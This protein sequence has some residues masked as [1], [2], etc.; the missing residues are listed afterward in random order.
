M[1][2]TL[3]CPLTPY[4]TRICAQC[5]AK[6]SIPDAVIREYVNKDGKVSQFSFGHFE[7]HYFESD[8]AA[9]VGDGRYDLPHNSDT[10]AVCGANLDVK[11][12]GKRMATDSPT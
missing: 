8:K 3:L 2:P 11:D 12:S 6:L 10:C 7:G 5:G 1:M 4:R 9:Y